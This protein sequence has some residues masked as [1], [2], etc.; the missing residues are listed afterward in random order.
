M[1]DILFRHYLLLIFDISALVAS[2]FMVITVVRCLLWVSDL[3][4]QSVSERKTHLYAVLVV[5]RL[6]PRKEINDFTHTRLRSQSV[7]WSGNT[8]DS[9][10]ATDSSHIGTL[11][12][13]HLQTYP[14]CQ[15]R[16]F[17]F[18]YQWTVEEIFVHSNSV[19]RFPKQS[20]LFE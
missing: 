16:I 3:I 10:I 6:E 1:Q 15:I 14:H 13:L 2:R 9:S 19:L 17:D 11:S 18:R 4:P 20:S 12:T 7:L 5:I 8:Y